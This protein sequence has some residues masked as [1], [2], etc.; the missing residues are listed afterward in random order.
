M[1]VWRLDSRR[2]DPL[3]N[4][5]KSVESHGVTHFL[6]VRS[7][8]DN[9]NGIPVRPPLKAKSRVKKHQWGRS[10]MSYLSQE[11]GMVECFI[12]VIHSCWI[13]RKSEKAAS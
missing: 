8:D 9:E 10:Q 5:S 7:K 3:T 13:L 6:P 2:D 11:H 1:Y 12:W 4:Q